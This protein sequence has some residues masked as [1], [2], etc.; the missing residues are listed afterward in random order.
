MLGPEQMHARLAVL[1]NAAAGAIDY[2]NV[3]RTIRALEVIFSTGRRFSDQKQRGLQLYN[4]IIIGITRPRVELYKRIDDRIDMMISSG[5]IDEVQRLLALGYS[6]ELPTMSAIGYGEIVSYLSG[7]ITLD[8]AII[9]MKRRTRDFV[10]RQANWFKPA[11]PSIH[12][13]EGNSNTINEIT[14]FVLGWLRS[15]KT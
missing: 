14:E 4:S 9:R 7:K 2:H 5:L 15:E 12:W 10:R 3:R 1:D 11:D 13:F 6:S 8:D